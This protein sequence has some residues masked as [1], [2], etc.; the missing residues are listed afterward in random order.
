MS[1]N[2]VTNLSSYQPIY[3][4]IYKSVYQSIYQ[5]IYLPIYLTVYP[6]IY[7]SIY[8]PIYHTICLG[9]ISIYLSI[10]GQSIC[11]PIYQS[12]NL[13]RLDP[14]LAD[15]RGDPSEVHPNGQTGIQVNKHKKILVLVC[16]N[17]SI[18]RFITLHTD[19]FWFIWI[20][21]S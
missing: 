11:Q 1:I 2:S 8:W 17:V 5:S 13:S 15:P 7:R 4:Y 18:L 9:L 10:T 21:G 19:L 20:V 12:S 3:Q 16:R 14:P 6:S